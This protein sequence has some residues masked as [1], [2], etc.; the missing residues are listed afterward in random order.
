VAASVGLVFLGLPVVALVARSIASGALGTEL[1]ERAV[2]DALALS[3]M[4]S[5]VSVGV[6]V[7]LGIP[8]AL[9]LARHAFRGRVVAEALVDL[10]IILPPS[11]AGLALLF[12]FGR[13]GAVGPALEVFG[14]TLPFTTVAVVL[15]QVFVSMPFFIRAAR[16]GIRSVPRELEDAARVDGATENAV[17]RRVSLPLAASALGA[18][19]V[20]A[21]ARAMGEFGATILFAGNI[22]GRTQTLPLLVYSEFQG[23]L[24]A[25]VAAA[26][27]LVV[28]A[29]G[30]LIAVRLLRLPWDAG[31]SS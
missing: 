23:S 11:V 19:V 25:A 7:V 8:I 29:V 26:T 1:A 15:A 27:I 9:L 16:A 31:W 24:D 17:V 21:W 3:L 2:L 12:A 4:T 6:G 13:R 28:A 14:L 10:P 30:V 22:E 5:T 18:G 20:L